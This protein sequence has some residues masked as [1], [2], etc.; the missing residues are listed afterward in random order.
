MDC[1][2]LEEAADIAFNLRLDTRTGVCAF[3]ITNRMREDSDSPRLANS[4][5]PRSSSELLE[6]AYQELRH[7]AAARMARESQGHTL[8]ATAL[9]HEAWLQ[10]S[11]ENAGVWKNRAQ[12]VGVAAEAM[13]RILI[14]SARRRT[15]QKRGGKSERLGVEEVEVAD[16]HP[17]GE[18]LRI[19]AALELLEREDPAQAR[20]VV[21]KFFGGMTNEEAADFLGVS[22]RTIYRHWVCAKARLADLVLHAE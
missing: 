17:P 19:N 13:R 11:K 16:T 15:S 22:E 7:L 12:F 18:I 6:Q 5:I 2:R 8:Q 14:D 10:I 21:L 3:I 4:D 1:H 9:V 20:V